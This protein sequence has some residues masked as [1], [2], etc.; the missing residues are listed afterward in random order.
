MTEI[1]EYGIDAVSG[2]AIYALLTLG[3]ALVFSV[4]GLI[5]F[6]YGELIMTGGFTMWV[7]R[8]AP[9]PVT[10][11]GLV[12]VVVA[13]SVLTERLAFRPLRHADPTTMLVAA[14]AV[15]VVLQNIARMIMGPIAKGVP[16]YPWLTHNLDVAGLQV[17]RMDIITVIAGVVVVVALVALIRKTT[18]GVHL[19]ASAED[20]EMAEILGVRSN[21]VISAAFAITG[22]LAAVAGFFLIARQGSVSVT[23]GSVPV[24]I[25]FV[26]AVVGGMGSLTGA[27]IGGFALGALTSVLDAA[28]GSG[29]SAFRDAFVFGA[30]ILV[31][32]IRPQGLIAA[33]A[34]RV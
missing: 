20:A 25:A 30:V 12:V 4:M 7:L 10:L 17:S 32:V 5:N 21:T 14:F 31:L 15:S 3:L 1:L 29:L 24:L 18:L 8:D 19:R 16:P 9:V 26:G 23:V 34:A 22:L 6:A 27:A 11:V 13:V 33:P 2:G 28:L